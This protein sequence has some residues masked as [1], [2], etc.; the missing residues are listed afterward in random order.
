MR[1][2]YIGHATLLIEVAGTRILTDPNFDPHLGRFLRRVSPPGIPL[3]NLPELDAI[4][5]SHA[6][7]D[8]LSFETLEQL[9]SGIPIFAPP[10]TAK[11]LQRVGHRTAEPLAPGEKVKVGQ[12]AVSAAEAVH[13][14][15]RYGIDQWRRA[16]NMYLMLTDTVSCFFAGDTALTE[17]TTRLVEEELLACGRRLDIALLPIGH[18]PWW[19][20]G[21]RSGHLTSGDAL[22]LFERLHAKYL[23]PYHWGT[24][25]HVTATAF[26]AINRFRSLTEYHP[27]REAVR[28]LEPGMTFELPEVN[29]E[30]T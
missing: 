29:Q 18:S 23:I 8:H 11:W 30:S 4:F 27:R 16:A 22:V 10:P 9:P 17:S 7:A 28:V 21:F 3:G 25:N 26:D 24:F 14:G 2:T 6:H 20:P 19:R 5:V 12:V 1:I 13:S 15:S